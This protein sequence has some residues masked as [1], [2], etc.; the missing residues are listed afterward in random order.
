[1][2]NK[3]FPYFAACVLTYVGVT[4]FEVIVLNNLIDIVSTSDLV[5]LIVYL[6]LMLT[7]NPILTRLITDRI[8]F[9]IKNEESGN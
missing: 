4:L 5:H 1:M 8:D 6:V 3:A 7:A 2:G 9:S